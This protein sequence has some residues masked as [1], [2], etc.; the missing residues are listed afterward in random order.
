MKAVILKET[1]APEVL[2]VSEVEIPKI[3]PGWVLIKIK[4]FG[5]NRSELMTR[6]GHSPSV[7]FPRIIGIEC[8]GEVVDK[9]DSNLKNGQRVVTLMNGLGRAFDG[10]YAEYTLVPSQQVYPIESTMD[11]VNFAAIPETY[12]TAYGSLFSSLRLEKPDVLL[13]R[14]ATSSVG[15]AAIQL[16]KSIDC[17]VIA[18]TRSKEKTELLK[19][20]GAD[21]IIIDNDKLVDEIYRLY[22]NG[23]HKVLEL[24]GASTL[25]SS[26][27]LLQKGGVVCMS[28]VLSGWIIDEFE[29]LVDMHSGTY[30]T[31]FE[32]SEVDLSLLTKLYKHMEEYKIQPRVAKVFSFDDIQDA[33]RFMEDNKANG[34]I[35]VRV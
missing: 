14:G 27:K 6:Q 33:H 19:S 15:I 11:W 20:V 8:V 1:G 2:K 34:K 23:V 5:I 10:S 18:T 24:V 22:P 3:K 25:K 4:A 30:F 13:I 31:V 9:S 21:H 32:S 12:S 7:K 35:V 16:A 28:G 29:P 17:T 26:M